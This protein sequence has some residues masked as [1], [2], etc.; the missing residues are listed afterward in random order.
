VRNGTMNKIDPRAN[1]G[2]L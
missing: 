1:K 2:W